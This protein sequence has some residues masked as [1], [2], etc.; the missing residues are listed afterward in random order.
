MLAGP[1]DAAGCPD[2]G[3]LLVTFGYAQIESGFA[4]YSVDVAG[5]DPRF[6]GPAFAANTAAIVAGQLVA[7]RAIR[8]RRRTSMLATVAP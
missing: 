1:D 7:L 5:P 4:A 6:L 8:G 3:L 2:L